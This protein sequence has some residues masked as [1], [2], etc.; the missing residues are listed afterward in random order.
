MRARVERMPVI[1]WRAGA[2]KRN[3]PVFSIRE[4]ASRAKM[5]WHALARRP[6]LWRADEL[7]AVQRALPAQLMDFLMTTVS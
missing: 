2:P 7:D 6:L 1:C 4:R 5:G 3:R